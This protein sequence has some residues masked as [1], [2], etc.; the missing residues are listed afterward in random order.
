MKIILLASFN[1]KMTFIE[2]LIENLLQKENEVVLVDIINK[3]ILDVKECKNLFPSVISYICRK[4]KIGLFIS[5]LYIRYY[6]W[7]NNKNIDVINIHYFSKIYTYLFK[8]TKLFNNKI[9]ITIWGSDM[10][11]TSESIKKIQNVFMNEVKIISVV[12]KQ[13]KNDLLEYYEIKNSKIRIARFGIKKFEM[14]KEI[15]ENINVT[16]IRNELSLPKN[17]IL[18]CCGYNGI[19]EQRHEIIVNALAELPQNIK[20]NIYLIFHMGYGSSSDYILAIR[21]K[22][23]FTKIE[24]II[25]D[26]YLTEKH[27]ALLRLATDITINIQT[28]DALSASLVEHIYA[29]NIM[30][31]G[32]WLP[33]NIFDEIGIF[34]IK[35][36]LERLNESI[37][38][39]IRNYENFK[40]KCEDNSM[41]IYEFGSWNP[42][43][44]DWLEIYKEI[45]G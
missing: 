29:K 21:N 28:T 12:S 14:M 30:L 37:L 26:N 42:R 45:C 19:K 16:D 8:W 33:Y 34:Y 3:E 9:M 36:S 7:K 23:N 24:H 32:D 4:N 35:T 13:M 6:L 27:V 40:N 43:I 10:Y 15:L 39:V 17:K 41:K 25:I 44:N 5:L 1:R 38:Y 22:V 18:I 31:V 20:N 2:E 11:R